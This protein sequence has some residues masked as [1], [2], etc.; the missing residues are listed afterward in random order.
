MSK[1]TALQKPPTTRLT[2]QPITIDQGLQALYVI[3]V[4]EH[5]T[6]QI[7][8]ALALHSFVYR[9][10]CLFTQP[11]QRTQ[12]FKTAVDHL[13]QACVNK[14]NEVNPSS[15]NSATLALTI[16]KAI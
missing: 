1:Q 9:N 12:C 16:S 4:N 7:N 14:G 5:C 2:K 13:L 6:K 11:Q 15:I 10:F 8:G 3:I